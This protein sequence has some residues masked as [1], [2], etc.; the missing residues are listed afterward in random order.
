MGVSAA[1]N[2]D[3]SHQ[4]RG[5]SVEVP[6]PSGGGPFI[7]SPAEVL[8]FVRPPSF[9]RGTRIGS[10]PTK[11]SAEREHRQIQEVTHDIKNLSKTKSVLG[12]SNITDTGSST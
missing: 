4:V 9:A 10:V 2:R 8:I 11:Q 3:R 6:A 7:T 5:Y 1:D 12:I